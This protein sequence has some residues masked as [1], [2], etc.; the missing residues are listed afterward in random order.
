MIFCQ[1]SLS[2]YADAISISEVEELGHGSQLS[3]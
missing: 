2:G 3:E 1:G